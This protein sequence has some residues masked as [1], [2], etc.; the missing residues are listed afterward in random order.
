MEE[1]LWKERVKEEYVLTRNS[2]GTHLWSQTLPGS[3]SSQMSLSSGSLLLRSNRPRS[4]TGP[5]SSGFV[6][7]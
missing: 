3:E 7:A 6:A 5:S 4:E 2:G 1:G